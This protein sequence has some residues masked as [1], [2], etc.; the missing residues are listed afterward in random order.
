MFGSVADHLA[1]TFGTKG[2]PISLST[3]CAS[4]ATAI[5]LG[6]EAIRRGETDAAL[7]VATDGSVNPEALVR[8]SLLSALSTQNDP[9]QAASK[10]FSKNRD[11]FVMAEGAGA[12]VLESFEAAVARGAKILGVV[13]GCGELTELVSPHPLQPRRQTDHRLR[14]QGAG[15]CRHDAG[16]DRLHQRAR[17]R[18]RRKTTRWNISASPPC[19]ASAPSRFRCRPTNPWSAIPSR[20]RARSKRYSRC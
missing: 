8:F 1:E 15:G 2:S 19:S 6:V 16:A 18:A 17:H 20:R 3:A 11:G 10:P 13:A 12:L 4:G 5:Q 9:P 14:A 7:C